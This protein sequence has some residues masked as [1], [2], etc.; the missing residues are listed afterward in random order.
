MHFAALLISGPAVYSEI[1]FKRDLQ[2]FTLD[3]LIM[4]RERIDV[5]GSDNALEEDQRPIL[6]LCVYGI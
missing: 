3:T 2:R 5:H 1:L 6:Y 4:L